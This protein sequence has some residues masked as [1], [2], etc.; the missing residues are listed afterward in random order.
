MKDTGLMSYRTKLFEALPLAGSY[1]HIENW[2]EFTRE[3][4]LLQRAGVIESFHR[5]FWQ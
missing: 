4:H 3:I 5:E 2:T 1:S